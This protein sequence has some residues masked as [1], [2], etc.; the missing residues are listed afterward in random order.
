MGMLKQLLVTY[1]GFMTYGTTEGVPHMVGPP[2]SGKST[3][4]QQLAELLGVRL[5]I[6]SVARMNP[7]ES[8]GVQMPVGDGEDLVLKMLPAAMWNDLGEG[9]IVFFDEF[10]RGFPEVYNALLD[11]FTSRRVGNH[12]LPKVFML[13]ASN[14]MSTY[15]DALKD[16]LLPMPVPDPRKSVAEK[17]KMIQMLID[18]LGLHPDMKDALEMVN[19]MDNVV[20]PTYNV[21][22][23]LMGNKARTV[24]PKAHQQT[25]GEG[26]SI[27]NL[28]AQAQL[29]MIETRE[30]QILI[31]ESNRV[32]MNEGKPQYVILLNEKGPK[33][34]IENA[35]KWLGGSKNLTPVQ[36]KNLEMNLQIIDLAE[37]GKEKVE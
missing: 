34:Y 10:L 16:R 33:A 14:S 23:V 2:G 35:R 8:E 29:R 3:V 7:M 1:A 26:K 11:V 28:V 6:I 31:E 32:A 30:L 5:H 18:I 9:D 25:V 19:L 37:A 27:R 13:A 17:K 15:D 4:A 21:M 20:L 12:H 36:Q 22:D 24:Q